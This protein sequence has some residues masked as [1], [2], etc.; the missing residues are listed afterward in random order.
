MRGFWELFEDVADHE[1]LELFAVV[2]VVV[3]DE[4]FE[5]LCRELADLADCGGGEDAVHDPEVERLAECVEVGGAHHA[6][7]FDGLVRVAGGD[8]GERVDGLV[9]HLGCLN[10]AGD[11]VG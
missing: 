2:D 1:V 10:V 7:G 5:C 3:L 9:A 11:G 4:A 8:E 6:E